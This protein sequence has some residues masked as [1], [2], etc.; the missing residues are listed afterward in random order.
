M[1]TE[2]NIVEFNGENWSVWSDMFIGKLLS[3]EIYSEIFGI[4]KPNQDES[5]IKIWNKANHKAVGMLRISL[6]LKHNYLIRGNMDFNDCWKTLTKEF[7]NKDTPSKLQLSI[8]YENLKLDQ[9]EDL[10]KFVSKIDELLKKM[11]ELD[12]C[13]KDED[14]GAKVL[15]ILSSSVNHKSVFDTVTASG[16]SISYKSIRAILSNRGQFLSAAG[17]NTSPPLAFQTSDKKKIIC[18]NCKKP[19]HKKADCW[20]KGGGKEGQGPNR[21]KNTKKEIALMTV[22]SINSTKQQKFKSQPNNQNGFNSTWFLDSGASTHM[23][24]DPSLITD[25]KLPEADYVTVAN[26]ERVRVVGSGDIRCSFDD[27][28]VV[29]KDVLVIPNLNVNLISVRRLDESKC[30]LSFSQGKC[31]VSLPNGTI[32]NGWLSD[33]MLYEV[34]L[35]VIKHSAGMTKTLSPVA[36]ATWMEHARNGHLE[37]DGKTCAV[38]NEGK[39]RSLPVPK[40]KEN[41]MKAQPGEHLYVD[42]VGPFETSGVNGER[43]ACILGDAGSNFKLVKC[44][45]RKAETID[46]L[47][48]CISLM[49]TQTGNR[50]KTVYSDNA[51]EFLDSELL[52]FYSKLSH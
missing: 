49:E 31:Q 35:K 50:V 26:G 52:D 12:H 18:H 11:S 19:G 41:S 22:N 30:R 6:G 8:E 48:S 40:K 2:E 16:G 28:V 5:E 43:F 20:G 37:P 36:H 34:S 46:F 10:T 14:I 23:T 44:M 9:D 39:M 42:T 3:K 29:F 47:K 45:K 33:K 32:I 17:N 25:M 38:C 51:A 13:P 4:E 7:A 15:A 27:C 21:K 1:K 24:N